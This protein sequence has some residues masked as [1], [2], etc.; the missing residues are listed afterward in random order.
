MLQKNLPRLE[1]MEP[2]ARFGYLLGYNSASPTQ[3]SILPI[4]VGSIHTYS[5]QKL[6]A[7]VNRKKELDQSKAAQAHLQREHRAVGANSILPANGTGILD[8]A[9]NTDRGHVSPF[10]LRQASDDLENLTFQ[11]GHDPIRKSTGR[12]PEL[13]QEQAQETAASRKRPMADES[14]TRRTRVRNDW[15]GPLPTPSPNTSPVPRSTTTWEQRYNSAI[16]NLRNTGTRT[17]DQQPVN[18]D[19]RLEVLR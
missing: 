4:L 10:A 6:D 17:V 7:S 14:N 1:K 19:A 5:T 18:D 2:R 11:D 8:L 3:D 12:A 13:S 16:G 9:M 15:P